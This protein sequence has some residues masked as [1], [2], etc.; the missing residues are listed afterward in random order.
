MTYEEQTTLIKELVANV[1]GDIIKE[2]IKYPETW[3]GVEIRW[4]LAEVFSQVVFGQFVNKRDKRYKD[5]KNF[6]IVNDLI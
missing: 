1:Q 6:C 5:Y 4:R 3:D 2:S